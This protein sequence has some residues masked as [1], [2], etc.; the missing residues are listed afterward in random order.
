[1]SQSPLVSVVIPSYNR[2]KFSLRAIDSVRRQSYP[3][4]ELVFV[5]DGSEEDYSEVESLLQTMSAKYLTTLN[6]GVAS[7]RNLGIQNCTG[8]FVAF[9]DSDDEWLEN[10]IAK[11]V[12]VFNAN[13]KLKVVQTL[14]K[15]LRSGEEV[16]IPSKLLPAHGDGFEKAIKHCCISPS[17]VMIRREIFDSLGVFD[18]NLRI[19]ED[20]DLWLRILDHYPVFCIQE[21]LTIRHGGHAGQLSISEDA[22]DRFRV[23][24]LIKYLFTAKDLNK[25]KLV[26]DALRGKLSILE[27]GAKKRNLQME[28]EK[29][30]YLNSKLNGFEA[31]DENRILDELLAVSVQL[32]KLKAA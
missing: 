14:E 29:Y 25:I 17:A 6:L 1:M 3:K 20:Y 8:A 28:V 21:Q 11:Q 32:M 27:K 2:A 13:P 24:A 7:A 16:K 10:K 22:I 18:S 12:E 9:L 5:N 19:C 31:V 23:Y 26:L 4:I 15:W 30:Q